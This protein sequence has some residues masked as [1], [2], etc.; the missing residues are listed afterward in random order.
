MRF[1]F[2]SLF[3]T[4][5]S[6]LLYSCLSEEDYSLSSTERLT[7]ATDTLAFDTVI[8]GEP[9]NTYTTQIFNHNSKAIR[10]SRAYL[11][12]GEQS[13]FRINLDGE[14]LEGGSSG[15]LEISAGDSLRIFAELT[16][17]R[18]DTDTPQKIEE[19]LFFVLESGI[20]QKLLLT[21]SGQDVTV[22]RGVVI[23]KDVAWSSS[24][25]YQ[26]FD[27]LVV[28]KGATLT[29][30]PG[31]KLLFHPSASLIVHGR[32]LAEG[33]RE[34]P[35]EMR[36]DRLGYMFSNQP[37]DRIPNQWG[38]LI[39]TSTSLNN[40]LNYCDIHSGSFGIRC[41]ST[42]TNSQKILLQNSIIHNVGG[43]AFHAQLC[44][45]F[46][47]NSQISNAG[48]DCVHLVGGSHSFVHCTIGRFYVFRGTEGV[49]L[50]FSNH[51]ND[52]RMPL[53]QADF[54]N[55]LITGYGAD[56]VISEKSV[57]YKEE[58]FNYKFSHC[59]LNTPKATSEFL[60]NCLFE[61]DSPSDTR[62]E[63]NFSP[64]FDL[65]RLLFSFVLSPQSAAKGKAD[66]IVSQKNYPTDR[67]GKDR[68]ADGIPDIGC[69][70]ASLL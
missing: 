11:G 64:G 53:N 41:D 28:A 31:C 62:R 10:I 27:S 19:T 42:K 16:A 15:S 3:Y 29:L 61:E 1:F 5:M 49:A 54:T 65:K 66:A 48:E 52:T 69:Y 39:F 12:K 70:E 30:S 8:A 50:R 55:C 51:E 2:L 26:I 9:T 34:A 38:G 68:F 60:I 43:D 21:A 44:N 56:E 33:S 7:F 6:F 14:Y 18:T 46:V 22:M 17:P 57:R 32:L 40:Q 59:L 24:R 23:D 36:G 45:T 37:Y 67:L 4:V 47:G 35:I 13:P 58:P 20:S 63:Q 25:P